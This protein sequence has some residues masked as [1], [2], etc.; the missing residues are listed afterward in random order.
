MF[1]RTRVHVQV[2]QVKRRCLPGG[3]LNLPMLEEYDF[4]N[5][6][7][8]PDLHVRLTCSLKEQGFWQSLG[9]LACWIKTHRVTVMCVLH[10]R[11]WQVARQSA[12]ARSSVWDMCR[13]EFL[14]DCGVCA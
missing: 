14:L 12:T 13:M 1:D 4:R 2:E 10:M 11:G 3:G 6:R 7:N 8:T 9:G 5:D